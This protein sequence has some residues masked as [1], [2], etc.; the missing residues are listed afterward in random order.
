MHYWGYVMERLLNGDP[1]RKNRAPRRPRD[2]RS[3]SARG[4]RGWSRTAPWL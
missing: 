1:V 2:E 3:E 4:G